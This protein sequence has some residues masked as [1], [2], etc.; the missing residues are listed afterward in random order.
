MRTAC[1][2]HKL[3]YKRL[4]YF[5]FYNKLFSLPADILKYGILEQQFFHTKQKFLEQ[6]R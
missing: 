5:K 6:N 1:A 2:Y 3:K 4:L